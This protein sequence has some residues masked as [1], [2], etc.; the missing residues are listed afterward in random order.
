MDDIVLIEWIDSE[1]QH[2][3]QRGPI[4]PKIPTCKSIGCLV[5]S[6]DQVKIIVPHF[7]VEDDPQHAGVMLIPTC[8]VINI[9]KLKEVPR[10]AGS[11][12]GQPL[13]RRS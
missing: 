6:D 1:S 13:I 4:Q 11:E 5:H 12:D 9:T 10:E 3:W 2:A 7:T 8:C